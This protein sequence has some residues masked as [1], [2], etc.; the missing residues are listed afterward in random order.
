MMKFFSIVLMLPLRKMLEHE[1]KYSVF[2]CVLWMLFG[3]IYLYIFYF[4]V[5]NISSFI[6]GRQNDLFIIYSSIF[7]IPTI[8]VL[9]A[10][11]ALVTERVAMALGISSLLGFEKGSLRNS[12]RRFA[13]VHKDGKE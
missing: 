7:L 5:S 1:E 4:V 11:I 9:Y 6:F 10:C 8:P 12:I 2:A 13:K 3:I